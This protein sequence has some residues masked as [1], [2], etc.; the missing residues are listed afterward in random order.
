MRK[1][2]LIVAMDA[3]GGIGKNGTL[4][5]SIKKDMQYFV[6]TTKKVEN[7]EK[8]NAVLMGR[9]CWESIPESRRPLAGRLNIVLSRQLA[10]Q[11]SNDLII[12]NS[13]ESALKMLSEPPFVDSIETIWNIGGAEIYQLAINEKLVDEIHITKIYKSFDADNNQNNKKTETPAMTNGTASATSSTTNPSIGV[14]QNQNHVNN[15]VVNTAA[16]VNLAIGSEKILTTSNA[17]SSSVTAPNNTSTTSFSSQ[18]L[19]TY[20]NQASFNKEGGGA[21][22]A[23]K[24]TVIFFS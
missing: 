23:K 1:M 20:S 5:W 22:K 8:R 13:F 12:T 11:K 2:S 14:I 19:P 6:K 18:R 16:P 17:T 24:D 15:G 3:D 9:K 21:Q 10:E 7:P 4:P